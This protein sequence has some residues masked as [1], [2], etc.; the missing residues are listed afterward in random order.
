[1]PSRCFLLFALAL[2]TAPGAPS[3]TVNLAIEPASAPVP[4]ALETNAEP[5]TRRMAAVRIRAGAFDARAAKAAAEALARTRAGRNLAE[6]APASE[7]HLF[8]DTRV[9]V[10]WGRVE[11]APRGRGHVWTG[12]IRNSPLSS[13]TLITS[14]DGRVT[15]NVVRGNGT[16]YQIR[17]TG[18]GLQYV[19]E[20]DPRQLPPD[21]PPTIPDPPPGPADDPRGRAA[22][23][24]DTGRGADDGSV[25][26]VIVLY[27]AQARQRQ[28][29]GEA[30]DQL[31]ELGIAETNQGYENSGVRHRLRLVHS[32]EVNYQESGDMARDLSRLAQTDDG[33]LDDVHRL[34]NTYSADLVSLWVEGGDA[35]GIAYLPR[36]MSPPNPGTGFSVVGRECATGYYSFGHEIGHNL[37]ATHGADDNT[38]PGLYPYSYAFKNLQGDRYRTIMAYNTNCNCPRLNYWSNHE[39]QVRGVPAGRPPNGADPAANALTLNN[40]SPVVANYRVA[41]DGGTPPPPGTPALPESTHPYTNGLDQTWSYSIPGASGLSVSFDPRTSTEP[42]YDFIHVMNGQSQGIAGSPFTGGALAGRTVQVSGDTVRIRLTTDGSLTDYGFRVTAVTAIGGGGALP[43]LEITS[44]T[45]PASGEAGSPIAVRAEVANRGNAAAGAFRLSIYFSADR[46]ITAADIR[47]GSCNFANG[48]AAGATSACSGDLTVPASLPPGDWYLGAIADDLNQVAQSSREGNAAAA[49]NP[50]R[51][52][53]GSPAEIVSPAPGS[54]LNSTA[55]TFQW[56]AGTGVSGY[57]LRVG[58]NPDTAEL[59]DQDLGLARSATVTGL[60]TNG[61]ALSVRLL[62][63]IGGGEV[64]RAYTYRAP[65]Q[66]SGGAL[67]RLVVREFSAPTEGEAGGLMDGLRA[68]IANEGDGPTGPFRLAFYYGQTRDVSPGSVFSGWFCNFA[69]GLAAGVSTTCT[70]Q[71]GV[72]GS[73][74]PGE[75]YLAAIADDEGRVQQSDRSGNIRVNE[76]GATVIGGRSPA[77]MLSPD[78]GST[79]PGSTVTFRWTRGSGGDQFVLYLGDEPGSDNLLARDLETT[80]SATLE[81]L[82]VDGRTI[83]ARLFTRF[84]DAWYYRDYSYR[85][86]NLG[87]TLPRLVM[88]RFTAPVTGSAGGQLAGM[89]LTVQNQGNANAPP[90]RIGFYYDRTPNVTTAS[91]DS[92]W[93]CNVSAGLAAGA[94]FT[95]SGQVGIPASLSP[96]DY[97]LAAIADDTGLVPQSSRDGNRMLNQNGTVRITSQSGGATPLPESEH[98]Y[99]NNLDLSWNYAGAN[100]AAHLRIAFD[101][102]TSLEPGYDFLHVLNARGEPVEGSP[103]SGRQLAGRTITVN[104]GSVRLRLITDGSIT[105]WGFRVTSVEE[106]AAGPLPR[107]EV[108]AF[109]APTTGTIGSRLP[110]TSMTVRNTGTADAA[111]FRV[112]Y[113]WGPSANV[114]AADTDSGWYCD[115]SEGLR[116]GASFT[117]TGEVGIPATLSPGAWYLAAIADPANRIP[118]SSRDGASRVNE[119]G[120]TRLTSAGAGSA[121]PESDHPYANNTDR[122]W[123]YTLGGNPTSLR[124]TFDA[125]TSF[126]WLFDYL[127]I[128]DRGGNQVPGSPFT[129]SDLAGRTVAVPGDQVQLRLVTDESITDW[130]F[131]VTS[132]TAGAPDELPAGRT[133]QQ[134]FDSSESR[135]G[136]PALQ[137]R[138]ASSAPA[139]AIHDARPAPLPAPLLDRAPQPG[140]V[141]TRPQ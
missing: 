113:Y 117:C 71:V 55:V 22:M 138:A 100:P 139:P 50:I 106:V 4:P 37:G 111:A 105:D 112:V 9:T 33:F 47:A 58:L 89:S 64:E 46:A 87:A 57:R 108:V 85:A 92:G 42:G 84:A 101:P 10:E 137:K 94:S 36:T 62:S 76:R 82:P 60:P 44:I 77:E 12:A 3:Q 20:V 21:H 128:R 98:P 127:V 48:L 135:P 29:G 110:G 90:F 19:R 95:C 136:L 6:S 26:D 45:G 51:I 38:G 121:L 34:R 63:R 120:A 2:V 11:R 81:G 134:S 132:I 39:I 79:L 129:G 17:T 23:N 97:Y 40:S 123:T 65:L 99:A 109:T 116:A 114:T 74:T 102:R 24:A 1:M 16:V 67:P 30:M 104:T 56:S 131:R 49:A 118:V 18:D 80:L 75:W 119:N 66:G 8:V 140:A 31:V 59:F 52:G 68:V 61:A 91:I 86:A 73:L 88:T 35:C 115:V 15:G 72:P 93:L 32:G 53:G 25:I 78:N 122:T 125:R 70:G 27:T 5:W 124:V 69:E 107:L 43:R 41:D 28:G 83:H 13:V 96:G 133:R 103:F 130:G 54:V 126:E 141:R 7:L 14:P